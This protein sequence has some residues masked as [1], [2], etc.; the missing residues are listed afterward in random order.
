LQD[1]QGYTET[2]CLEKPKMKKKKEKRKEG[3]SLEH[4]GTRYSF[5]N[6]TQVAQPGNTI[7]N[8]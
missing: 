8:K 2:P 5:L 6:T 1:S 7:I 4:I 3:N